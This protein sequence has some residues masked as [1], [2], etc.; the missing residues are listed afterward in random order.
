MTFKRQAF[1]D[2]F[3]FIMVL[4]LFS[5]PVSTQEIETEETLRLKAFKTVYPNTS[6]KYRGA[7]AID[8][9]GGG[10][11]E[12]IC[13]FGSNGVWIWDYG[14]TKLNAGNPDWIIAFEH[15]G[16]EFLLADFGSSGLWYWYYNGT[17]TGQWVKIS[18]ADASFGFVVDDDGDGNDSVHISFGSL[19]L[20][21]Y[22]MGSATSW[23]K[24]NNLSP[25]TNSL[26][27]RLGG[28]VTTSKTS[29][30]PIEEGIFDF[31]STIGLWR[32]W[33]SPPNWY[34]LNNLSP[35]DDNVA[36][37]IYGGPADVLIMD[38]G[39]QGLWLYNHFVSPPCWFK[40]SGSD[41]YDIRAVR[42]SGEGISL[43]CCFGGVSG[44]WKWIHTGPSYSEGTWT[45]ISAITPDWDGGFCERFVFD[46]Y[47]YQ[48]GMLTD[49][50]SN[51]LWQSS[52]GSYWYKISNNDAEF[53]VKF[54]P[55]GVGTNTWVA[56]DFGPSIGLWMW[57]GDLKGWYKMSSFSPDGVN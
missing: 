18:N 27:A 39:S 54:D 21:R 29:F 47:T 15:Y 24:L 2:L 7:V 1:L 25:T 31:G 40:L 33:G 5:I 50:G 48:G 45:K 4:F 19:G 35:G 51:G 30:W 11:D 49:F 6:I 34:K 55:E 53:M 13:D 46:A 26:K 28:L 43:V 14:F 52:G 8:M 38:F 3:L 37:D 56:V 42:F 44:L 22:D 12:L 32:L 16:T 20:W 57:H 10:A 41:P 9:D 23:T 36:A 17:L